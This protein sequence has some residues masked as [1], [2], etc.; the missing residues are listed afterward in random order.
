LGKRCG[1]LHL[2]SLYLAKMKGLNKMYIIF[3][4]EATCWREDK[5][6]QN[7]TIEIGAVKVN[8]HGLIV[9]TFETFVKPSIH[10]TLSTFCTELTTIT[11]KDV[12]NADTFPEAIKK[13]RD[14]MGAEYTLCSW[15]E[16]DRKQLIRDCAL[17]GLESSWATRH[18]SLKHQ[19][20]DQYKISK[21]KAGMGHALRFYNI[22]LDG[23]HHRGIDDAKNITKI[24]L[25]NFE[26][27][28]WG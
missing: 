20:M 11:Q 6:K 5:S 8:K 9:G 18:V 12:D 1:R 24:F 25:A 16:Y 10:P 15:G 21:K 2:F 17:H 28:K 4:L 14:W 13:F 19:W 7:E 26:N 22:K 27:W 23:T 3:D